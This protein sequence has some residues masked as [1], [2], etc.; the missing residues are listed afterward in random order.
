MAAPPQL[1]AFLCCLD[2][3]AVQHETDEAENGTDPTGQH[4]CLAL[5]RPS[6][7]SNA[8]RHIGPAPSAK[9]LSM[10]PHL[11]KPN[12][13]CHSR[14]V[15]ARSK[16]RQVPVT[17]N[18][19]PWHAESTVLQS[20]GCCS[21]K[22]D[23]LPPF[24]CN[25]C[26]QQQCAAAH[27]PSPISTAGLFC[28]ALILWQAI[29][30]DLRVPLVSLVPW[31]VASKGSLRGASPGSESSPLSPGRFLGRRPS[32]LSTIARGRVTTDPQSQKGGRQR[33]RH[34]RGAQPQL[35]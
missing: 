30:A 19:S 6:A 12:R 21:L 22:S 11:G 7:S 8:R 4:H 10:S 35:I 17:M 15:A 31:A 23:K 1:P 29:H 26:G 25:L 28:A 2:S 16:R 34:S 33:F 9:P 24:L 3:L 32:V 5:S 13:P 20:M 27:R 18:L 14:R